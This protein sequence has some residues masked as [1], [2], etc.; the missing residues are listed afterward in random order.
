MPANFT[1]SSFSFCQLVHK[2]ES[3]RNTV[4]QKRLV[5]VCN[6]FCV[7]KIQCCKKIYGIHK[8]KINTGVGENFVKHN[9]N[10]HEGLKVLHS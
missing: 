5:D 9:R 7:N 8:K 4:S 3:S 6:L 1:C 2:L 10:K